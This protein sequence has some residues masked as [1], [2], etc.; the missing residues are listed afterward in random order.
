MSE[1]SASCKSCLC[2][3][4]FIASLLVQHSLGILRQRRVH[5]LYSSVLQRRLLN[6]A[7]GGRFVN[8][9]DFCSVFSIT[10]SH[11]AET[12]IAGGKHLLGFRN[13]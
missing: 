6:A 3:V 9:K 5:K 10:I 2:K 4:S 7:E 12:E 13:I 11:C 1:R 8:E